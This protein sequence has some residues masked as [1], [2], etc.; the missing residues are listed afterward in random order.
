MNISAGC[1]GALLG[2]LLASMVQAQNADDSDLIMNM[3]QSVDLL[4]TTLEE[5]LGLNERRGVFSPRAG[6]VRGRY[7]RGQGVVLEIMTPL[8]TREGF[9]MDA[10]SSSLSQLTTQLE[11]MLQQGAVVRP[12]F[13]VMRDQLALSLRSDEV[14]AYYRELMQQLQIA[15]DIPAIER[16][17][18]GAASSLQ[19][20]QSLG[21]IDAATRERLTQQLHN[22]QEQLRQ[23]MSQW[24]SLRRD[25]MEQLQRTGTLPDASV[26]QMWMD[27]RARLDVELTALRANV[28]EQA[29]EIERQREQ[30]ELLRRQQVA[31]ALED[32][33]SRLFVLLCDYA[34]GL[35]TL[36]VN[37][38][39]SVVLAGVGDTV[40]DGLR[41]DVVYQ[42]SKETL[43]SCQQ[44]QITAIQLR[45]RSLRY[46]Y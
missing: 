2:V 41:R 30:A 18:A 20:L 42:V 13:E 45:E 35:R 25:I 32:F 28:I 16:G 33:Q 31:A 8:Q 26:Q 10:F 21:Q 39:V 44:G 1:S 7:L 27:T 5:G 3:R 24:E 46:Q 22:Q 11:G 4:S 17:L 34:A 15:Q 29:A 19:S 12:D 36:P 23:Q 9:S 14:A 43:Q 40:N 38:S 6:D 37:E